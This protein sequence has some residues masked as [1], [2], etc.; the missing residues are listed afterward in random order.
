MSH[1]P[2]TQHSYWLDSAKPTDFPQLDD[3]IVC[4][5][6]IIGGGI[7]G[8]TVA[9]R[10]KQAGLKVVVLE[11]N[12]IASG[13]TGGTT[14]KVTTQHGLIY[15]ELTKQ[16]GHDFVKRY[17]ELSQQAFD[18]IRELVRTQ[19]LKCDWH[20]AD[21]YVYTTQA[22]TVAA[23][24]HEAAAA[25]GVGLPA[26]FET[27]LDLPFETKGAVRFADQA[28]FNAPKYVRELARL[29]DGDGSYV[30]EHSEAKRIHK[31]GPCEVKTKQGIV[32][33][34]N[35]I[36]ATKV[37]A[38]PLVGRLTYALGEYPVTSYVVA[39]TYDGQLQGMYISPDS[40]QYSLLPIDTSAGRVLLVGGQSHIPG[41]KRAKPQHQKLADYAQQ[42]FDV[43]DIS[44]RWKAMDYIAY[45]SLPIV[46][47]L[48][49]LSTR[50]YMIG[51]FK[52]WGLNLSMVA[53]NLLTEA[54]V[55]QNQEALILFSP[56]RLSAPASIPKATVKYFK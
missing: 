56:H 27:K 5:V 29:V 19:K 18:D 15:A 2:D 49:P 32:K 21:N 11:K 43:T 28:Y 24:K 23:L 30:F 39:G 6:V 55:N 52:K 40:S 13:T 10:L 38:A 9:Y 37:P 51:G 7:A 44:F 12:T 46:G 34:T 14:G 54:I 22:D 26:S 41:I 47:P 31:R 8:I 48:Y 16:F 53:A 45:D 20:T 17:A 33:A 3:E 42:Q 1:I 25:A 50:A 35:L 4:D 36:V